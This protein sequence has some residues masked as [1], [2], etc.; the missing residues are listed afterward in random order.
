MSG[1]VSVQPHTI[2]NPQPY[3]QPDSQPHPLA[4][5]RASDLHHPGEQEFV[6]LTTCLTASF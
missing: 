5:T 4:N 2:A 6:L 1:S 3:P